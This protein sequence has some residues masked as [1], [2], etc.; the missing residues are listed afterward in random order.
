MEFLNGSE[1][2]GLPNPEHRTDSFT[3]AQMLSIHLDGDLVGVTCQAPL[4]HSLKWLKAS[5]T[6]S[7]T[8]STVATDS[9]QSDPK[10]WSNESFIVLGYSVLACIVVIILMTMVFL[11][12]KRYIKQQV[13]E[14]LHFVRGTST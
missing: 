3:F 2:V 8:L 10:I 5:I 4:R 12:T 9:S 7:G 1:T 11:G 13:E 6:I 14:I